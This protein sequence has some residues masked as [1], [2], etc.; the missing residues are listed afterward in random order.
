MIRKMIII[1]FFIIGFVSNVFAV[2]D[3]KFEAN[4]KT[5]SGE[6]LMLTGKL[7][8]PEGKGPFPAIVMLHPCI[9]V[10]KEMDNW[11]E[12]FVSWGYVTLQV[13]SFGPR[14]VTCNPGEISFNSESVLRSNRKRA[15]DSHDAKTY[16]AKLPYVNS[17]KIGLIGWGHGGW[18]LNAELSKRIFLKNRGNPFTAAVA[19]CPFVSQTLKDNMDAPL[20][21]LHAELDTEDRV[22]RLPM[23]VPSGKTDHERIYHIYPGVTFGFDWEGF[24]EAVEGFDKA[25]A[26]VKVKYNPEI[27]EDA[28]GRT[29]E[30]FGKYLQ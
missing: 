9:E 23:M 12:R 2:E 11:A 13:N 17:N 1:L 20:L 24:D 28:F 22:E 3:V 14:G 25:V 7:R 6:Q 16:L 26:G 19:Y 15:Q 5:Q 18:A 4:D 29:K 8:K 27:A 10:R 30:F 21:I